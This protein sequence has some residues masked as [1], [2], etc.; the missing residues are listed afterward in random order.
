MLS[1]SLLCDA[2]VSF[3]RLLARHINKHSYAPRRFATSSPI[4]AEDTA[5]AATANEAAAEAPPHSLV[6]GVDEAGRGAVVRDFLFPISGVCLAFNVSKSTRFAFL[7]QIGPLVIGACV[8]SPAQE[9]MLTRAGVRD[10]KEL[11]PSARERL[12]AVIR[13][14]CCALT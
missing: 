13:G 14:R 2:G 9:A 11:S 12:A 5:S 10:S 6:C 7:A 4:P 8:L 3:R 1:R